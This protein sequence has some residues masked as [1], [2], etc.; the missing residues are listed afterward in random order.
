[1]SHCDVLYFGNSIHPSVH[2][3]G[4][5]VGTQYYLGIGVQCAYECY[6]PLLPLDV[7][8][9]LGLVHEHHS[10]AVLLYQRGKQDHEQLL[11]S[12]GE[13][14]GLQR[15]AILAEEYLVAAADNCLGC[16]GEQFVHQVLELLFGL[17]QLG[18]KPLVVRVAGSEQRYDPVAYIYLVVQVAA[19]EIVELPVELGAYI[20]SRYL[21][22]DLPA[23]YGPVDAAYHIEVDACGI[24]GEELYQHAVLGV[25]GEPSFTHYLQMVCRT[26]DYGALAH[27][28][29]ATE[30]VYVRAQ[31]PNY[32]LAVAPQGVNLNA[33][34]NR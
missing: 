15:L 4:G 32:M 20:S 31:L 23:H 6:E 25:A 18:G 22:K 1:M 13:H 3:Y 14:V 28:V 29:A 7:Q 16:G 24:L 33:L 17:C 11:L 34:D 26:V 10:G 8:R 21:V 30:D 5:G 19:L 12:R 27:T 9:Y 2:Y